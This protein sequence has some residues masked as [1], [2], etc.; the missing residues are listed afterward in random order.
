MILMTMVLQK[1]WV[2]KKGCGMDYDN[3]M[4]FYIRY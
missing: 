4:V 2:S 3:F 1:I